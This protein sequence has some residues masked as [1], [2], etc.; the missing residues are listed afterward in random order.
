MTWSSPRAALDYLQK[1][2]DMFGDWHLA[3]ASYNWGEGAVSRAVAKNRRAG[4]PTRYVDLKMPKETQYY[5]PKL[6]AIKNIIADPE[7]VRHG[8]AADRQ[9]AVFHRSP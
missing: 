5:V 8:V 4:K 7:K 6:Q 9:R 3:L 2:H 1:L